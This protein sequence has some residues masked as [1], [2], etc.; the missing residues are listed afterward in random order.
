MT[1]AG[2]MPA[3]EMVGVGCAILGGLLDN[4]GV[5]LQ[6]MSHLHLQAEDARG[7]YWTQRRWLAGVALYLTGSVMNALGLGLGR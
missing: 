5:C 3:S 2:G 4:F 6:K 1:M 7:R